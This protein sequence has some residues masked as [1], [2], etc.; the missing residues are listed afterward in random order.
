MITNNEHAYLIGLFQTDGSL[1]FNNGKFR[2]TLE[3]SIKDI[4][5]L[6]KIQ[7]LF[8]NEVHVGRSIR[9]RKT[10]FKNNYTSCVLR[11]YSKDFINKYFTNWIPVGEKSEI[12]S[13]PLWCNSK[14][15]IRGLIDGDGSLGITSTGIPFISLC[16][17]S[18]LVKNYIL[19]FLEKEFNIYKNISRNKRD[20]IYNISLFNEDAIKVSRF[21]YE[22]N[23]ISLPRKFSKFNEMLLWK[24]NKPSRKGNPR[25]WK[26][27]E[28]KMVIS[29]NFS[30]EEK[31]KI[32]N[33]SK[34]SIQTRIWR[35]QS[36]N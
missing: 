23:E 24:R 18:D 7:D 3:L 36:N 16:T 1:S 6:D 22:N 2:L 11:F 9:A 5:I 26:E 27:H 30:I 32:L 31:I 29:N 17:K 34:K 25:K 15:Y 35:L 21:L 4:Q 14:D 10:N 20:S 33:R 28:D 13:P 8:N 12:I 19:E